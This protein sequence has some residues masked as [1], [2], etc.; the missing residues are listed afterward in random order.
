M[1]VNEILSATN[2][3]QFI[4]FGIVGLSNTLISYGTY[5]GLTF[6]GVPYILSSVI[7]FFISVLNSFYWNNKYVFKQGNGE[8]RNMWAALIK[9]F[10]AYAGTG[11]VLNNILLYIGVEYLHFSKYIVPIFTLVITVPINFLVNKFWSF[12]SK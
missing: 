10:A 8:K 3:T 11:F 12:R 4:K 5:A 6:L 2:I 7:A 9:T 1:K